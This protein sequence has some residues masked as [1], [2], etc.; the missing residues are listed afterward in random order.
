[1][2]V[3]VRR[4]KGKRAHKA[5]GFIEYFWL[6]AHKISFEKI[7]FKRVMRETESVNKCKR[8]AP[9]LQLAELQWCGF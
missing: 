5:V 1:M 7:V 4:R 9:F 6:G 2:M 8:R 3:E